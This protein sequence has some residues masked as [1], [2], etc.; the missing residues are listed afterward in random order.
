MQNAAANH[1]AR[2]AILNKMNS[3]KILMKSKKELRPQSAF[4]GILPPDRNI[5]AI[6]NQSNEDLSYTEAG[7]LKNKLTFMTVL[8]SRQYKIGQPADSNSKDTTL[9]QN[10]VSEELNK[11][12]SKQNFVSDKSNL[13]LI[14]NSSMR[15]LTAV[16]ADSNQYM[17]RYGDKRT[18]TQRH[19]LGGNQYKRPTTT[20]ESK[21]NLINQSSGLNVASTNHTLA[22]QGVGYHP[23]KFGDMIAQSHKNLGDA[24]HRQSI[25]SQGISINRD[26]SKSRFSMNNPHQMVTGPTPVVNNGRVA[27]SHMMGN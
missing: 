12:E 2:P 25:S 16:R 1:T 13:R 19:M 14:E 4:G 15:P 23:K 6:C 3:N 5:K 24:F 11:F 26:Q 21:H 27:S 20:Y 8:H 7:I 17:N 18:K 10:W 9:P 22:T